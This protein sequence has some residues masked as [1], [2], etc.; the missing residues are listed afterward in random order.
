MNSDYKPISIAVDVQSGF[1]FPSSS[2]TDDGVPIVRMSNLKQGKLDFENTKYVSEKWLRISPTFVLN[3]GDFMLGMSGSLSNYAYAKIEDLPAL[4]NQRVARIRKKD[5]EVCYKYICYW[6]TS[7]HYSYYADAQGEGAAQKNIS[8]T[9][10]S[11]FKIRFPNI[12]EQQKIAAILTS[13]DTAIEKTA[14]LIEKYQQIKA[15]LMHD[16]FTRGVTADGKLCPP[17]EQAPELYQETLLGYFPIDWKIIPLGKISNIASGITLNSKFI[18]EQKIQVP[19]LRVANVQDGYLDLT[20]VK[21]VFA[22]QKTIDNL[23]L[24][25]GDVLM[26]EGGDFDKL[27]RGTVWQGEIKLCIHQN[28]VFRVRVNDSIL[29]PYFLA[30]WSESSFGKK[31]FVLNSKQSTNLASINSKQLN[32]YPILV[33]DIT[34]QAE[35]ENRINAV[36]KRLNTLKREQEK[37]TLQKQGLMQDLLT[38][39]VRVKV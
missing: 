16:L 29:R 10:I 22:D 33:P 2:F 19:Y 36:N 18:P 8:P 12:E 38:G 4:L 32:A 35:I 7:W 9:Q 1:A 14:A 11:S 39:K 17:R 3:E 15:G 37:L 31:Y 23:A 27:G 25:V 24:K 20:D 30:F 6:L 26:N 34:E 13:I 21:T 5:K 28:H